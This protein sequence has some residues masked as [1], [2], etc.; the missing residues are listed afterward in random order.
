MPTL[1]EILKSDGWSDADLAASAT[2]LQD[3]RFRASM[4]KQYGAVAAERDFLTD[5]RETTANPHIA[6]VE[7]REVAART[8]AARLA[9]LVKIAKEYG[10][11]GVENP[12]APPAAAAQP[13]N[14][15]TGE[16]VDRAA[17]DSYGRDFAMGQRKAM[18]QYVDISNE[19][20]RLFGHPVESFESLLSDIDNL[21]AHERGRLGLKDVWARKYNVEGK[22]AEIRAAEQAAHDKKIRDEA[23]RETEMKYVQQ[24]ANPL[25]RTP[26]PSTQPFIPTRMG[27]GNKP[28][29]PW[30]EPKGVMKERRISSALK[31]QF[32]S[33]AV[34]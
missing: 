12:I 7:A 27:E 23:V 18:A 24:R 3:Q 19:H 16:Y 1:E 15:A 31:S 17:L 28:V 5:W 11:P 32:E 9:E 2:L 20:Q 8:E 14:P 30:E 26:A 33:E 10:V 6:A 21:P 29:Q 22:R 4:E 25:L 34:N 13:R